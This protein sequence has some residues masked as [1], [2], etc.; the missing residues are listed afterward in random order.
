MVTFLRAENEC[1]LRKNGKINV[2]TK[3]KMLQQN[4]EFS[5]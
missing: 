3:F 4:F 5:V 2:S 1:R